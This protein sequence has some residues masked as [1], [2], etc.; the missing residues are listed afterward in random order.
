MTTATATILKRLTR[1]TK[2]IKVKGTTTSIKTTT[3]GK[4]ISSIMARGVITMKRE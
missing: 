3:T 4:I 2:T 1:T